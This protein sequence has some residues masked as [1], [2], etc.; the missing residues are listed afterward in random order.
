MVAAGRGPSGLMAGWR[1]VGNR[2]RRRRPDFGLAA[3]PIIL[4]YAALGLVG[5]GLLIVAAAAISSAVLLGWGLWAFVLGFGVAGLMLYSSKIGRVRVRD[6]LLDVLQMHGEDDV[7][8]LGC[9]SGL[10][11]LGAAA[12]HRNRNRPVAGPRPIRRRAGRAL[13]RR[14]LHR[15]PR[16]ATSRRTE[17]AV[18]PG[19]SDQRRVVRIRL[20][21]PRLSG[22]QPG[23]VLRVSRTSDGTERRRSEMA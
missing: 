10:M 23:L 9:G 22:S 13:L 2:R 7:L 1:Y 6:R 19:T 8:D 11:L 16:R 4:G 21:R 18:V 14:S 3:P 17:E 15:L 20:R 5:V 12:R